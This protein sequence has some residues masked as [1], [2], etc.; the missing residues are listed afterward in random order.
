VSGPGQGSYNFVARQP[1]FTTDEK[2]FGYELLFRDGVEDYF[3]EQDPDAA[4]RKA[5]DTSKVDV[6]ATTFLLPDFRCTLAA[7]QLF[8]PGAPQ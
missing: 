1:I 6:R 2:V 7:V 8:L 4:S 3:R 5:L